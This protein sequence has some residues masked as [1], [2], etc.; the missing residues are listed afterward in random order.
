MKVEMFVQ[1]VQDMHGRLNELYQGASTSIQ[2][3]SDLLLPVAFKELGM[4]SEALQV[5]SEQLF[6]HTEEL[7][8]AQAQVE[9]ERQRYQDLFEFMPVAYLMTDT[10]GK[11]QEANRAAAK[12][13]NVELSLLVN[14]LLV[15]FIPIQDRQVFRY[16]LNQMCSCDSVQEWT[17]R[18]QP[19]KGQLFD[20]A[21]TVAPVRNSQGNLVSL[22]WIL[23]DIT[24]HKRA[25]LAL[26]CHDYD[27]TQNRLKHFYSKG[28]LISLEPDQLYIVCQGLV[29]LSTM[30]EKGEEIVVGLA[31]SSMPFGSSMTSL[32]TYSAI[33]LSETVELVAIPLTEI[34][35][36]PRLAQALLPQVSE[37]VRQTECLL[38]I[39]GKRHVKER[40]YYLLLFLKQEIGQTVAQG[41]RLA[42]RLT[43]QDLA[44][45]CC[46]PRVTIT[47]LL[48]QLQQQGKI[49]FD[50]KHHILF[51]DL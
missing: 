9:A 29:K 17:L 10:Q 46:T 7:A 45:A 20:A 15:S 30:N 41:T 47:R 37:R 35:A 5:A 39:S 16:K 50:S 24:E 23:R 13:L 8:A 40:L 22:R 36:S 26:K 11:I 3:Q 34:S 2:L 27:P 18:L 19:G 4:A 1:Q 14:K 21:L 49:K 28:E 43:H 6:Q 48:S 12:L 38:A 42:V 25:Q 32:P 33:A 51:T 44:D 31:G